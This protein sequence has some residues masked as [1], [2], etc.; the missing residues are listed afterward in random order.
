MSHLATFCQKSGSTV[1]RCAHQGLCIPPIAWKEATCFSNLKNVKRSASYLTRIYVCVSQKQRIAAG[2]YRHERANWKLDQLMFFAWHNHVQ[3]FFLCWLVVCWPCCQNMQ[4]TY[5]VWVP[6]DVTASEK[7]WIFA[8][9]KSQFWVLTLW[10]HGGARKGSLLG[11][12]EK[13][14]HSQCQVRW[15]PHNPPETVLREACIQCFN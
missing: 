4:G 9:G 2:R 15:C 5:I 12:K 7:T 14:S 3:N 8:T 13:W 1:Q 6:V 10:V 11:S